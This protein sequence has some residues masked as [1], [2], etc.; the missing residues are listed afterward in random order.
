VPFLL[1]FLLPLLLPLLVA[2]L[3]AKVTSAMVLP[4]YCREEDFISRALFFPVHCS[5]FTVHS[6]SAAVL[7]ALILIGKTLSAKLKLAE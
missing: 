4:D 5:L 6:R 3:Q 1:P 7:H 2:V